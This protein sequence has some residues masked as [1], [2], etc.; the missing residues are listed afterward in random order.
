MDSKRNVVPFN[1]RVPAGAKNELRYRVRTPCSMEKVTVRIYPGAV[2]NLH[3]DPHVET[4]KGT[5]IEV[6]DYVAKTY[7]DGDN[8]L[9]PYSVNIPLDVD[10][11][12][13]VGYENL[14]GVNPYDFSVT[15]E[16]DYHRGAVRSDVK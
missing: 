11:E 4:P 14:D 7:L 9:L 2:L 15:F 8:D 1:F 3:L 13:V 12:I 10:D 5:R 6:F 16:L